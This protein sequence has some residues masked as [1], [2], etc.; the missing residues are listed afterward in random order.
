M[1]AALTAHKLEPK[2]LQAVQKQTD[3]AP[4]LFLLEARKD[5]RPALTWEPPLVLYNDDGTPSAAMRRI[6][7][8]IQTREGESL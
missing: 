6:Y 7:R 8:E 2:R 4:W 1:L 3:T 5:G